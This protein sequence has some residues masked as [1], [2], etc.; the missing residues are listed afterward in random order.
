MEF[1]RLIVLKRIMSEEYWRR[2]LEQNGK[3]YRQ[4]VNSIKSILNEN[5][6]FAAEIPTNECVLLLFS[7]GMDSTILVDVIVRKWNCKLI[8][9]YFRRNAR[10]QIFEEES[11]DY[12]FDF[13][14]KRFPDNVLELQKLE[15]EIPSRVN[16]EYLDRARQNIMG[17]PLRNSTMW[18]NAFAQAVFLSGK[19]KTTIR[20]IIVGSVKEDETSPES[21]ILSILAFN[22]HGC[23]SMGVWYYQLLAPFIDG[24]ME[25][26]YR[27]LDLL[28]Y[29]K[30]FQ[31]PIE[32][33][34]SCFGSD[35]ESCG[36]CLACQNRNKA[37]KEFNLLVN[38]K[39]NKKM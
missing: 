5:R 31:I 22:L 38:L 12:F 16:K 36:T 24:T 15:I 6:G 8:L 39:E 11:V 18:D 13:Y 14:K 20:T 27:K 4:N 28:Q 2:L 34:R 32:K 21:G 25:K 35:K 37:Y 26:S 3:M 30:Q 23:I 1:E 19:F 29:A 9:L 7:G 33:T 10:N 17:L